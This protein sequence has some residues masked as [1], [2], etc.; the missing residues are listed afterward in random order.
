[1]QFQMGDA[2]SY[3][4]DYLTTEGSMD[5]K[6]ITGEAQLTSYTTYTTT[7][8]N[9][10][11]DYITTMLLENSLSYGDDDDTPVMFQSLQTIYDSSNSLINTN[12]GLA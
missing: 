8:A 3:K 6:E 11:A 4:D 1:M 2:E 9:S 5:S 10:S 12:Y 7:A